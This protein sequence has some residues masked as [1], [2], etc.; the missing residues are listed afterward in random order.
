MKLNKDFKWG[1]FLIM[2][3]IAVSLGFTTAMI[4]SSTIKNFI[5]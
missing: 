4:I 3:Y 1:A 2:L 5:L